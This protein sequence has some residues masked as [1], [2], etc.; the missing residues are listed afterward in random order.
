VLEVV[1]AGK[2]KSALLTSFTLSLTYVESHLLPALRKSGCEKLDILVDTAGY[3]DS[4]IEQRSLGVGR[5]YSV[6]PVRV[7]GGIF[8]PKL[9]YLEAAQPSDDL[10][11]VGS[12]NVTYPGGGGNL[13]VLEVLPASECARSISACADFFEQLGAT[14]RVQFPAA[15]ELEP[16]IAR[17]RVAAGAGANTQDVRFIHCLRESGM[18]QFLEAA[19]AAGHSWDELLVLSPYHHPSADPVLELA[20]RLG[21]SSLLAGVPGRKTDTSAFPFAEARKRFSRV[22][23]VAAVPATAPERNLHAKWFEA[24]RTG[25]SL[26]LTGSFNATVASF[27]SCENVECGVLRRLPDATDCWAPAPEPKFSKGDFPRRADLQSPCLYASIEDG[28]TLRGA[29]LGN[30]R[31]EAVW[32][33]RLESDEEILFSDEVLLAADGSFSVPLSDEFDSTGVGPLQVS[34]EQGDVRG[35]G[36]VQFGQVLRLSS[37]HRRLLDIGR[38]AAAGRSTDDDYSQI[39]ELVF[40]HLATEHFNRST[41]EP[42]PTGQKGNRPAQALSRQAFSRFSPGETLPPVNTEHAMV[43]GLT[44]GTTGIEQARLELEHFF[45]RKKTHRGNP[46]ASSSKAKLFTVDAENGPTGSESDAAD[47]QDT[48]QAQRE[49]RVSVEKSSKLQR[50]YELLRAKLE[51]VDKELERRPPDSE[52]LQEVRLKLLHTWFDLVWFIG[53]QQSEDRAAEEAFL[54]SRWLQQVCAT[55]APIESRIPLA[56][57]VCGVAALQA[58][59]LVSSAAPNAAPENSDSLQAFNPQRELPRRLQAYFGRPLDRDAVL[60]AARRWLGS[61]YA[62]KLVDGRTEEAVA[63]LSRALAVPTERD[64]LTTLLKE[65]APPV[66][67]LLDGYSQSVAALFRDIADTAKRAPDRI[68]SVEVQRLNQCPNRYCPQ[69]FEKTLGGVRSLDSD[70]RWRL[71][72]F[73]AYRCRCGHFLV[74]REAS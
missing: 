22:E 42:H 27:A 61:D 60:A 68:H 24:R 19:S 33:L 41:A 50:T 58:L 43:T 48:A 6:L 4:L 23:P 21:V 38:R 15:H 49:E 7:K 66:K 17:M 20:E 36:W 10:L 40:R 34:I 18:G 67:A 56:D 44:A 73:G 47:A 64:V 9:V 55:R 29:L 5:D 37:G 26:V 72:K 54:E 65:G 59:A 74:T 35:R 1:A 14:P 39:A 3:R 12:G 52:H 31:S 13:E 71:N 2:W 30:P 32:E 45:S 70:I 69:I 25:E 62:Q 16:Y 63:A 51:E 53:M 8:H 46:D 28:K 11:L 57:Q